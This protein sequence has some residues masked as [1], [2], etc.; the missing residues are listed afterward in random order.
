MG[1]VARVRH[2]RE[3]ESI[4]SNTARG[5]ACLLY[6][7]TRIE[8]QKSS[9]PSS[10][11]EIFQFA[12]SPISPRWWRKTNSTRC[13]D[14]TI[15]GLRTSWTVGR[16]RGRSRHRSSRR[17]SSRSSRSGPRMR[18]RCRASAGRCPVHH[19][20]H[21]HHHPGGSLGTA[22]SGF[23]WSTFAASDYTANIASHVVDFYHTTWNLF[24]THYGKAAP[25]LSSR[26]TS[27]VPW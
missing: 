8:S 24:L 2:V 11:H 15:V 23:D 14:Q 16:A 25:T 4:K 26:T 9:K 6:H 18:P 27:T 1:R 22:I 19:H 7:K 13:L 10:T 12:I 17:S 5:S 20:R 21:G 3:R